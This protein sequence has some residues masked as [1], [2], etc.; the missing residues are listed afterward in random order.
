LPHLYN[1]K[2]S[3]VAAC[4]LF[5]C[6]LPSRAATLEQL[7]LDEMIAHSTAI[8]RAKV[9]EGGY[10]AASNSVIYTHIPI[11][12][13]ESLKG[14]LPTNEVAVPGGSVGQVSQTFEGAPVLRPGEEYVLFL[15]TSP[16]GLNQVIGLTQGLFAIAPSEAGLT[17]TRRASSEHMVARGTGRPVNDQ[18]LVMP[19]A[20]LRAR[21]ATALRTGASE[22]K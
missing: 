10:A 11:R 9:L 18:K 6:M 16:S 15:W 8:V 20:E 2:V 7:S 22:A 13:S 1:V 14:S 5:A 19:L 21:I 4:L 12:V 3:L 17:A